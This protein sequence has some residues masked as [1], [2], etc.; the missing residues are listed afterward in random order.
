MPR[1]RWCGGLL[2]MANL[3]ERLADRGFGHPCGVLGSI[4]GRVMARGNA[5]TERHLVDLA[6][7]NAT[8]AVV[9]LGPGPGVG[10]YEAATRA[11]HVVGVDP[12]ELMLATCRR[13]C[14]EFIARGTVELIHGDAGHVGR[15]DAS[16][17][18]VLSVNN[19]TLWPNWPHAFTGL[20]RILR[21]GGRLLLSAHA[22]WLPGGRDALTA[23][24]TAAGFDHVGTW[25]WDP[26]GRGATTAAQ[27]RATRPA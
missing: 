19:V 26:P 16:A 14:A 4:G 25:T 6:D 8:D 17:D 18:V 23:A 24:V 7:L 2:A 9:V 11:E 22:K 27:L 20:H 21:L 1:A 15:P 5:G 13:R 10:L 12:S 3:G